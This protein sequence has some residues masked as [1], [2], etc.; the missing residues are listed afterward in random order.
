MILNFKINYLFT[1]IP[2]PD[3]SG[4]PAGLK[5]NFSLHFGATKGS[6]EKALEK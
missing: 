2:S 5:A 3:S 4:N 1:T 6:H